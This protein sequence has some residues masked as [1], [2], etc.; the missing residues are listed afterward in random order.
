MKGQKFELTSLFFIRY[1]YS[2]FFASSMLKILKESA[3]HAG[4]NESF[5]FS[6]TAFST[7]R[8]NFNFARLLTYSPVSDIA[9]VSY[10]V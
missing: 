5:V 9:F 1:L 7:F 2:I 3:D 10:E 4:Y 6:E 8:T